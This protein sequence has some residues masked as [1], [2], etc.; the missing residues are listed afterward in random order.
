MS[1]PTQ[2]IS[3]S[4]VIEI[5][6]GQ[7]YDG[8]WA[9]Y[10]R[11]SGAC[12]GQSEGDWEDAVFYLHEGATLQ[13]VIIGANQAEGVHCNLE[14]VW[15]ED[16]CEDAISIVPAGSYSNII[17]GGAYHAED[18]VVQHNGCGT[19]NIINFYV[20]D[21][22]KL[23]RSCGNCS[24]QC[25]RN[26]YIEGVEAVDGGTLARSPGEPREVDVLCS[27]PALWSKD[28]PCQ[29]MR[30]SNHGASAVGEKTESRAG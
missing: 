10:D 18:K 26:V 24:S 17:G 4:A 29:T 5:A 28:V 7:T 8:S 25:K 13:N 1:Q 23:Y 20:E 3:N 14:F 30:H 11:G 12:N 27:V 6:A 16:V 2:T 22:G 21:Y 9:R 19:V 15:F